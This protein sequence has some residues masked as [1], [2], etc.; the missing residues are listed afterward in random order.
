[1]IERP[2]HLYLTLGVL[3]GGGANCMS[4]TAQS[5]FLPHWFVRKR[6]LAIGIA[7]A[8]VGVGAMVL[9]PWVQTIIQHEGWRAACLI[10]F[11]GAMFNNGDV[12]DR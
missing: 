6:G 11:E 10:R 8:G 7:F 1:M 12:P 4:Y 5:L 9:L 3:V 2:W